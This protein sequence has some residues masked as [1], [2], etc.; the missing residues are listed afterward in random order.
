LDAVY[1]LT[2]YAWDFRYPDDLSETYPTR[3]EF[4]EALQHAQTFYDFVLNPLPA[5]ARP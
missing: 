4:D 2:P 1:P 3:E 5:D